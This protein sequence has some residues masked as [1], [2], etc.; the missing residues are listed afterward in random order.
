VPRPIEHLPA[1]VRLGDPG[2]QLAD[3]DGDGHID[4]VISG[5]RV[6]GYLPLTVS[7]NQATGHFVQYTAA[8]PFPLNDPE[9][10]LL[11][12][13]GD[14]ITDALRTGAQFELYFHDRKLGWNRVETR[15]RS[16]F[17]RFPDVQFSDPRV[18]LADMNGD[19][20]QDIVFVS[21]GSVD[22]PN[23]C[24]CL[25]ALRQFACQFATIA[26][27]VNLAGGVLAGSVAGRADISAAPR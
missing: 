20:L 16:D 26:G 12:L 8:P 21:T 2:V 23:F 7:G 15:R 19:G 6:N 1:G 18:K 25:Q 5:G 11:D 22:Y 13:D 24:S 27:G 17:D 9:V 4:L 3:A 14:G 10:R